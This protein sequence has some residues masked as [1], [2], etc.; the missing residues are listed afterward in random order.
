[1]CAV[2]ESL[3]FRVCVSFSFFLSDGS[4]HEIQLV[5]MNKSVSCTLWQRILTLFE[6]KERPLALQ[7]DNHS[8]DVYVE[9]YIGR[10]EK[11]SKNKHVMC[12]NSVHIN[13]IS[14]SISI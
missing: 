12:F 13:G 3:I 6:K 1:M 2:I 5:S 10:K 11:Q 14:I 4:V 9:Q 7:I 8:I